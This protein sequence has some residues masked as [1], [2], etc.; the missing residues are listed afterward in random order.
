MHL[1]NYS[2]NKFSENFTENKD[3]DDD[4]NGNK[5][6][7]SAFL[8]FL[9]ENEI[10]TAPLIAQIEKIVLKTIIAVEPHIS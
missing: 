2:I 4:A 5:W 9:K 7:W 1:T 3:A 10:D 8:K 6:S